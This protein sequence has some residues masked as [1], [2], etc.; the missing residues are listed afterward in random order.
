MNDKC[1]AAVNYLIDLLS[2]LEHVTW[3]PV[4]NSK[5][6]GEMG[7]TIWLSIKLETL[8]LSHEQKSTWPFLPWRQTKPPRCFT[9]TSTLLLQ[10][11]K[12]PEQSKASL[13]TPVMIYHWSTSMNKP[14]EWERDSHH[15]S[16][17]TARS[18]THAWASRELD[19]PQAR[20]RWTGV[21][22]SKFL[23]PTHQ[24]PICSISV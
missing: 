9:C 2:V 7:E 18:F 10:V 6:K 8:E 4:A 16:T 11:L 19:V 5:L 21:W 15:Q 13:E 24:F 22:E 20:L 12:F 3:R 23:F 14:S 1:H 17:Q